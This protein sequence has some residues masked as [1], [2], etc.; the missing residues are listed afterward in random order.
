MKS[1]PGAVATGYSPGVNGLGMTRSLPLPVLT[2]TPT[3]VEIP[4]LKGQ[5]F[6]SSILESRSWGLTAYSNQNRRIEGLTPN[7][8]V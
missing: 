5:A 6:D 3:V 4:N 2:S 7:L 8:S 1:E